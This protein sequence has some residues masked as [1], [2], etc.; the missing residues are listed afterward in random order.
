MTSINI[1]DI[2]AGKPLTAE[3]KLELKKIFSKNITKSSSMGHELHSE[4][5]DLIISV[6]DAQFA[7]GVPNYEASAKQ[8]KDQMDKKYGPSWHCIMGE[9]F[10]F[11]V[12]YQLDHML[13]LY[14]QGSVAILLYKC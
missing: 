5:L 3:A 1:D 9:G 14:Y 13:Y 6:L 12:T 8:I 4:T 11:Q 10:G 7:N 2:K